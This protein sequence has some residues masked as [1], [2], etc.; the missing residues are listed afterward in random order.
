[1]ILLIQVWLSLLLLLL[2]LVMLLVLEL[3]VRVGACLLQIDLGLLILR[4]DSASSRPPD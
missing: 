1:M 4:Q 2:K 3:C